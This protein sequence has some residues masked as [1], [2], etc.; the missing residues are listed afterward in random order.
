MSSLGDDFCGKKIFYILDPI[1][2]SKNALFLRSNFGCGLVVV[3]GNMVWSRI[4]I[5]S[6]A[7]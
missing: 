1:F 6:F 5:I 7:C 4:D 2:L 3:V